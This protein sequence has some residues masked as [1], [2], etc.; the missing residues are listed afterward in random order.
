MEILGTYDP[1]AARS[2]FVSKPVWRELADAAAPDVWLVTD[3]AMP[4]VMY[5]RLAAQL[6]A[7][8]RIMV[9]DILG[10]PGR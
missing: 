10:L 6:G 2:R 8:E 3:L 4:Q 7:A 9:P 5:D 1:Q